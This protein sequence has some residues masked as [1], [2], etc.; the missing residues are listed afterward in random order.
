MISVGSVWRVCRL[1]HLVV[2]PDEGPLVLQPS[3]MPS[4]AVET[5]IP[6]KL[7]S[8]SIH[9]SSAPICNISVDP[10]LYKG[11]IFAARRQAAEV[12]RRAQQ[13]QQN[14]AKYRVDVIRSRLEQSLPLLNSSHQHPAH[15]RSS[16]NSKGNTSN[17]IPLST[18]APVFGRRSFLPPAVSIDKGFRARNLPQ[19]KRA[20]NNRIKQVRIKDSPSSVLPTPPPSARIQYLIVDSSV[21]TE[22][23]SEVEI[24]ILAKQLVSTA[25]LQAKENLF[26]EQRIEEFKIKANDAMLQLQSERQQKA[27]EERKLQEKLEQKEK[28]L[29]QQA[30][31]AQQAIMSKE[32]AMKTCKEVTSSSLSKL[33][34]LQRKNPKTRSIA[35]E[36]RLMNRSQQKMDLMTIELEKDF[37]PWLFAQAEQI[38]N[39]QIAASRLEDV[40]L[41]KE[42]TKSSNVF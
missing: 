18:G 25:I 10:R 8:S 11:S 6:E 36:T 29:E 21:Q 24:T 2:A 3:T 7:Q 23:T 31:R 19:L 17:G 34:K 30:I 1:P 15:T 9:S 16:R 22:D 20:D 12:A 40:V 42:K 35:I 37:F 26:A 5:M 38:S 32:L 13:E 41:R 14:E 27:E 33:E 39:Q 4:I 28:E